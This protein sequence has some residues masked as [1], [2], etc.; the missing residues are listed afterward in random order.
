MENYQGKISKY[1]NIG[2]GTL[3]TGPLGKVIEQL[4]YVGADGSECV[5]VSASDVLCV[6]MCE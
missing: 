5:S 6:R 1:N 4:T 3:T 2:Y